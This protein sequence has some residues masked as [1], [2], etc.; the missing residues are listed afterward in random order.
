MLYIAVT[1]FML[2]FVNYDGATAFLPMTVPFINA[3]VVKIHFGFVLIMLAL[4]I[5][6]GLMVGQLKMDTVGLCLLIKTIIDAIPFFRDGTEFWDYFWHWSCTGVALISY[7]L[8]I[9]SGL[10]EQDTDKVKKIFILFGI[11][12]TIQVVYTAIFGGYSFLDLKYKTAM[13]IPYGGS[14]IIASAILPII[15]LVFYRVKKPILKWILICCMGTA[16][17]LTKSRGGMLYGSA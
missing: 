9:N 1:L 12:L 11:V 13:V 14:N 17:I 7:L 16:V 2:A 5:L 8:V 3:H 4:L 10:K 6:T 15:F